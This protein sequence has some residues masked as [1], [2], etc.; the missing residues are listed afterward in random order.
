MPAKVLHPNL[1]LDSE[2]RKRCKDDLLPLLTRVRNDRNTY[3]ETLLRYWRIWSVQR[4]QQAYK[5]RQQTYLPLGRR[6]IENWTTR[7]VRDLFPQDRQ[8]DIL[9]RRKVYEQQAQN[10]KGLLTYFFDKHTQLRRNATPWARQLVTLG[11]SPVKVV[12]RQEEREVRFLEAQFDDDGKVSGRWEAKADTVVSCIGPT[13]KP[14]DLF[15]FYVW[16]YTVADVDD[17]TL[18]FEDVLVER[19]RCERLGRTTILPNGEEKRDGVTYGH[20]FEDVEELFEL[21]STGQE[22]DKFQAETRR[23][24]DKGFTQI[25]DLERKLP[26][27]LIPFD[28]TECVWNTDLEDEGHPRRYLV[29]VG[30]DKV[31]LRVQRLPFFHGRMHWLCG[32]FREVVNEFYGRALPEE[33]DKLQ[34]FLNDIGDQASDALV[35]SMNPIALVDIFACPDPTL[36]RMRPGAKWP[37]NTNPSN[38]VKFSEPPKESA[39]VGFNTVYNLIAMGREFSDVAPVIGK[40]PKTRNTSQKNMELGIQEAQVDVIEVVRSLEVSVMERFLPMAHALVQQYLDRDILLQIQGADG[41]TMIEHAVGVK[42]IIGDFEFNW[43][44]STKVLNEQVRAAQMT[45]AIGLLTK[46]PADQLA[47]Q[48]AEIG[49]VDLIRD[50]FEIGMGLPRP[51]VLKYIRDKAP[52]TTID[53]DIE[54]MLFLN[55]RGLEVVVSQADNDEEHAVTH[56]RLLERPDTPPDVQTLVFKHLQAHVASH[57]AKEQM[58]QMA[59]LQQAA[60][61]QGLV[62]AGQPGGGNGTRLA[63]PMG[64]GRMRSTMGFDDLLRAMPRPGGGGG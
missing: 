8:F 6:L 12:W 36:L 33:F 14:V 60:S 44:A 54:N 23:L 3:R 61:R 58:R 18:A 49:W 29:T 42:D 41:A 5:G 31:I 40:A 32:K 9:A 35:W 47:A 15:T 45:N 50:T 46:L 56:Q 10:L 52:Q 11:T 24:A 25:L 48:N 64:P 20:V 13:F 55:N 1:A 16:P 62:N 17:A 30:S 43:L 63:P 38:A 22:R 27:N 34:Y 51:Q 2:I 4:D 7:L 37:L 57:M 53:A 19:T 28:L 26:M 59:Q 21:Q 39:Q